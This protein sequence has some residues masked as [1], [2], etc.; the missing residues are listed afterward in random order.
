MLKK[1]R[2]QGLPVTV[3]IVAVLALIALVV[4]MAIFTGNYGKFSKDIQSCALKS[5][6]CRAACESGESQIDAECQKEKPKCC[7]KLIE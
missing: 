2:A 4:V 5:G 3:I 7:I 1:R 6:T